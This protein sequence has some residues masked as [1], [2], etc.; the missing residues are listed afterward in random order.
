MDC[1]DSDKRMYADV[2]QEEHR[3]SIKKLLIYFT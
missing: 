1:D 2:L 3:K